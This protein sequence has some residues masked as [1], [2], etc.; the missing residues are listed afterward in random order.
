MNLK[1]AMERI[2]QL[3]RKVA[4]LEKRPMQQI[5]YHTHT[6]APVYTQ[7]FMPYVQP[8]PQYPSV[9]CGGAI[10]AGGIGIGTPA[11]GSS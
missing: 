8:W 7:P 9:Y 6:P 5:N 11:I 2:E 10:G 4:E 1:Q 3:E